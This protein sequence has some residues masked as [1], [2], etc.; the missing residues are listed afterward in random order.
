MDVNSYL[1]RIGISR[2][3]READRAFLDELVCAHQF[4]VPFETIDVYDF[5]Q[6]PS[7]SLDDLFDKIVVRH[8]GGYCFELNTLF[9]ALLRELGY[10]TW[11]CRFRVSSAG[12]WGATTHR[13]TIVLLDGQRWYV[14]VGLGGP[15]PPFALNLE[16]ERRSAFGEPYWIESAEEGRFLL[17]RLK[18]VDG[19]SPDTFVEA[20]TGIFDPTPADDSVFEE[21]NVRVSA[22]ENAP[23]RRMRQANMRMEGG[24]RTIAGDTYSETIA[25]VRTE[26]PIDDLATTLARFGIVI[27]EFQQE[28]DTVL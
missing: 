18:H 6:V 22:G 12:E 25:N 21:A 20:T 3:G 26:W 9:C 14:D 24:H 7:L 8:R 23:F 27:P 17:R 2:E 4:H 15:M 5:H 13:G 1:A 28:T 19:A 16:G 11:G 10:N